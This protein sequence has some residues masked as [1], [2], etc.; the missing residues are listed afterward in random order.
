MKAIF[1]GHDFT[2]S[3]A[4]LLL[5]R[6]AQRA[7]AAGHKVDVVSVLSVPGPLT[8]MY[9][10]IG[11]GLPEKISSDEYDVCFGNTIFSGP[12]LGQFAQVLPSAWWLH[13]GDN[14]LNAIFEDPKSYKLAFSSVSKIIAQTGYSFDSIYRSF[15][16]NLSPERLQVIPNGVSLPD[17][18]LPKERSGKFRIVCLANIDGR[19]RQ[20]DLIE[21]LWRL[22]QADIE[23]VF[24][25][26]YF[27]LSASATEILEQKANSEFLARTNFMGALSHEEALSWLASAD[28]LV[29]PAGVE[30]QP[31]VLF[32]AGLFGK[33][34][35]LA[36]LPVYQGIWKHGRNCLMHPVGDIELMMES[37]LAIYRNSNLR[38]RLGEQ[39]R[40]TATEFPEDRFWM[41]MLGALFDHND[42]GG[43]RP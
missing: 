15:V 5:F 26:Q 31:L 6:F 14:G 25:G 11:V 37:I 36:E 20:G 12:V 8:D 18:V 38:S 41:R 40:K 33:P 30:S 19:K 1:I 42:H 10:Q 39:A 28:L 24:V 7:I 35:V 34:I 27:W 9:R 21:A 16:Y 4:S 23:V 2:I 3:G 29:H 22:N 13:E 32:E 43:W 17:A